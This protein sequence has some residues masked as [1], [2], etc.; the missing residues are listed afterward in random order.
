[1]ALFF[2]I[3][4]FIGAAMIVAAF[5]GKRK[6][7]GKSLAAINFV[8]AGLLGATMFYKTAWAGVAL[9]IV[10][11]SVAIND[12]VAAAKGKPSADHG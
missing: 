5:V 3:I 6:L 7:P 10:W 9:E 4:G 8:G 12:F 11:M 1:M 2:E